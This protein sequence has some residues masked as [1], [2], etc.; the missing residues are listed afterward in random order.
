MLNL[1]SQEIA[2][3]TQEQHQALLTVDSS[4]QQVRPLA[5]NVQ[6]HAPVSESVNQQLDSMAEHLKQFLLSF[7]H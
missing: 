1:T 4:A 3:G 7:C 6:R 5:D 2:R